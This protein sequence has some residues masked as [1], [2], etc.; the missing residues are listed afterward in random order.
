VEEETEE[1]KKGDRHSLPH[2]VASNFSAAVE[3][4]DDAAS[5]GNGL[6]G[7]L[8]HVLLH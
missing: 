2:E 7:L 6:A 3:P 4:I 5:S 1:E 8:A